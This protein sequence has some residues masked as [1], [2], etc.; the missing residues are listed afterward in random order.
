VMM[1]VQFLINA[2]HDLRAMA[3]RTAGT[4]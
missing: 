2:G 1:A 4:P 3:G